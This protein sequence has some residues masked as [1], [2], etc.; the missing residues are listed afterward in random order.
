[1]AYQMWSNGHRAKSDRIET[2][3]EPYEKCMKIFTPDSDSQSRKFEIKIDTWK[4]LLTFS[5]YYGRFDINRISSF[6]LVHDI[7]DSNENL[8]DLSRQMTQD[9]GT[10]IV[11]NS[12]I[13]YYNDWTY[14][15]EFYEKS[16]VISKLFTK[17]FWGK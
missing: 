12:I 2:F 6:I 5:N 13:Q 10:D 7:Q 16:E 17:I 1:M 14:I 9:N 11:F 4:T 8:Y 15:N 3:S